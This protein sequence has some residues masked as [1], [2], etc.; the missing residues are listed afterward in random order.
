MADGTTKIFRHTL[1]C[2]GIV[3]LC[4]GLPFVYQEDT[5][6]GVGYSVSALAFFILWVTDFPVW[7]RSKK[8]KPKDKPVPVPEIKEEDYAQYR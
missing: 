6:A 1:Y 4:I 2:V 3:I 8:K 7:K 5:W